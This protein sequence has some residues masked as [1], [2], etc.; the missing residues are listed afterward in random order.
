MIDCSRCGTRLFSYEINN[1]DGGCDDCI[2]AADARDAARWRA[3]AP[4]LRA[5][6]EAQRAYDEALSAL[7]GNNAAVG[8]AFECARN[9]RAEAL[10]AAYRAAEK[11]VGE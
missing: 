2:H 6:V 10:W 1:N 4:A 9:E 3:V 11:A 5:W 8:I 7:T